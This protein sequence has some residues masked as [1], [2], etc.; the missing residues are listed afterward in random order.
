MNKLIIA[1]FIAPLVAAMAFSAFAGTAIFPGADVSARD[2]CGGKVTSVPSGADVWVAPNQPWSG[3]S[4][5]LAKELDLTQSGELVVVVSNL[6][7]ETMPL[8]VHAKTRGFP[9]D[10]LVGGASLPPRAAGEIVVTAVSRSH[11]L[12][13]R[14]EGMRGYDVDPRAGGLDPRRIGTVD[15]FRA[16]RPEPGSFRVLSIATRGEG[17]T[18]AQAPKAGK[19]FFPMVDRYGQYQHGD[20]PGKV[21][22]DAELAEG[23]DRESAE[24]AAAVSPIP[25]ADRFGGWAKGPQLKATGFFRVEKVNG[26]WWYVDPDGHLFFSQ[27]IDCVHAGESTGTSLREHFFAWLP[28]TDDRRFAS[29][30]GRASWKAAHGFYANTNRVPYATFD[31]AKANHIRLYGDDWQA[32]Y[33]ERA[34][35]RFKSW[36]VNTIGNWSDPSVSQLRQTPYVATVHTGGFAKKLPRSQG[37]WGPLPDVYDSQYPAHVRRQVKNVAAWMKDDPWCVGVFVDNEMSWNDEPDTLKAAD[38]Y[39]SVVSAIMKEELPNHLYLGCRFMAS[40]GPGMYRAAAKYCDVV[41]VNIY[42]KVPRVDYPKDAVDRPLQIGEFHFGALDRGLFHTGLV[43]VASQAERAAAYRSYFEAVLDNPRMVG[44]H[45]FQY[46]D[47]AFTGRSD[48]ECYQIGF[49]T[50]V[51]RPYP[52]MVEAA[53]AVARTM[54]A[55]RAK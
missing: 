11:R 53:R 37:W 50:V 23:R 49:V 8:S 55:R 21:H 14:L 17:T 20:W 30:R 38:R 34:H 6:T 4:F 48:S 10:S 41:S 44:A 24:L 35:A 1:P 36:G 39:F 15:V 27:G 47:Q 28:A 19:G 40:A 26:V 51:D 45:W 46:R 32:A 16:R 2:L 18:L 12:G 54:Y 31:F 43:P 33:R 25:D 13:V 42:S 22:S 29:C 9:N 52:E 7:N 3:V 5:G